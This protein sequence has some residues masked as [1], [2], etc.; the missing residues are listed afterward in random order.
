MTSNFTSKGSVRM[1]DFHE[2]TDGHK[3]YKNNS[4]DM[5]HRL[6]FLKVIYDEIVW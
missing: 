5:T 6:A 1:D 4:V 3:A 2:V